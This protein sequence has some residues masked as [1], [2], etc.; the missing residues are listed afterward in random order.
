VKLR[1]GEWT[2]RVQNQEFRRGVQPPLHEDLRLALVLAEHLVAGLDEEPDNL[3]RTS[4]RYVEVIEAEP[5]TV[6]IRVDE[7]HPVGHVLPEGAVRDQV[8]VEL[9]LHVEDAEPVP[10]ADVLADH[11]LQERCLPTPAPANLEEMGIVGVRHEVH[12][13][14]RVAVPPE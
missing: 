4:V 6:L 1:D 10:K 3:V 9:P 13:A 14:F 7:D 12:A 11:E 2:V 5:V 8:L